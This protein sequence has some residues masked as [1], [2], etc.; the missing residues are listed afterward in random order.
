MCNNQNRK[1]LLHLFLYGLVLRLFVLFIMFLLDKNNIMLRHYY[2]DGIKFETFMDQYIANANHLI[3]KSSFQSILGSNYPTPLW[4]WI[5]F[6]IY[7]IFKSYW[8][9]RMINVILSS[10]SIVLTY[11]VLLK[12]AKKQETALFGAKLYAFLPYSIIVSCFPIKDILLTV[13][14][15]IAFNIIVKI[16]YNYTYRTLDILLLFLSTVAMYYIRGGLAEAILIFTAIS[17]FKRYMNKKQ[18][19]LTLL[20]FIVLILGIL[21][22]KFDDILNSFYT[23]VNIYLLNRDTSEGNNITFI[24]IDSLY[25]IYKLPFTYFF[26]L[27]QPI[28]F[29]VPSTISWSTI[30]HILNFSLIPISIGNFIYLFLKKEGNLFYYITLLLYL[31]II[32]LSVGISRHYFFLLPLSIMN[33]SIII[34]KNNTLYKQII[35]FGT[36]VLCTFIFIYML[37]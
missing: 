12:I 7:Y 33:F 1:I 2:E 34:L 37:I 32:I 35:Y 13:L 4:F 23:K 21:V 22:I 20:A 36:I 18:I 25:Q 6:I 29:S 17:F 31:S 3:D 11:H 30:I 15:L 16:M 26:S 9:I 5:M 14:T 27:F 10:L 24:R 8:V 19:R 28:I